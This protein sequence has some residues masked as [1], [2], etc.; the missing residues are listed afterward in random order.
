MYEQISNK[1]MRAMIV[2]QEHKYQKYEIVNSTFIVKGFIV[3]LF[4]FLFWGMD[5]EGDS[6]LGR[7]DAFQAALG[8]KSKEH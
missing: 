2:I 7:N 1:T 8:E 4:L 6:G 3:C 5:E